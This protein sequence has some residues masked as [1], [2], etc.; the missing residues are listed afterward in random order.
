ME[1]LDMIP[2]HI[3]GA[4]ERYVEE[5]IEP[6]GF[7][8]AVIKNDLVN[9]IGRA[10]SINKEHLEDIVRWFYNYAPADCWGSEENMRE[11]IKRGGLQSGE[12]II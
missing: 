5:G 12:E 1:N 8:S 7:L 9:A 11:W 4:V 2:S 3:R 6:G 10:D